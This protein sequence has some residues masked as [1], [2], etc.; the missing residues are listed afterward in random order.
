MVDTNSICIV[1]STASLTAFAAITMAYCRLY[2]RYRGMEE[3]CRNLEQLIFH[4]RA[5]RHDYLNQLQIICGLAELEEYEEL[6]RY[7]TPLY[8]DVQNTGKAL[9]TSK[10]ALNALIKAKMD[11]AANKEAEFRIEVKTDLGKLKI[12][13]WELCKVLSNLIDNALSAMEDQEGERLLELEILE[14]EDGYHFHIRN[15]G[16]EIPESIRSELF[17]KGFTTKKEEGHGLGLA[18]VKEVLNQ[19]HGDVTFHSDQDGTE[20]EVYLPKKTD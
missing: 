6:S 13:D 8:Q 9:R 18:I 10:P 20:F 19:N 17:R 3:N 1:I 12:E 2:R 16:P 14:S 11:E 15:S 4:L 5:G 7:L